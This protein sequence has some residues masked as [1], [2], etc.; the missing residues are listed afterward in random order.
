M[1]GEHDGFQRQHAYH[2]GS[3]P[4]V[5]G[6]RVA[7]NVTC[8]AS[9][10]IPACAG[11][12]PRR[13]GRGRLDR[14]HPRVC[15]EH[16]LVRSALKSLPGSSP[17]VRGTL[18]WLITLILLSG[19]H[20]RVCGEHTRF[21]VGR[22]RGAGSS[23]RVR[24][25]QGGAET[26]P[27]LYGIIPACAGNT[28]TPPVALVLAGDHP[29]VCG[30]HVMVITGPGGR[31]GSSPRVRGTPRAQ[32]PR[33][34]DPGIIPACAG[35]TTTRERTR[36]TVRDHPRVCGEHLLAYSISSGLP[37]SSP[38]VRGTPRLPPQR[39]PARGIIPACAGNTYVVKHTVKHSRDHPRVCG[40][41]ACS[42]RFVM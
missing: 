23:P 12:T 16:A 19:D 14:D 30:E 3:S 1:C 25:T 36:T 29:R 26:H 28:F 38:R 20:P 6:T 39:R 32:G 10:I 37:G 13:D 24:G 33:H 5:R 21:P 41:H 35:N 4:R 22:C 8:R 15:G 11:N 2:E 9:G 18:G 27:A 40:E 34:P 42:C 31:R 17:R 7:D